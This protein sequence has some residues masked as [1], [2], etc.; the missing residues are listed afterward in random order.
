MDVLQVKVDGFFCFCSFIDVSAHKTSL[1]DEVNPIANGSGS[2]GYFIVFEV[3][4]LDFILNE[5]CRCCTE[6]R[7]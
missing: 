2:Y 7:E 6:R 5:L 4:N 1:H 3:Q